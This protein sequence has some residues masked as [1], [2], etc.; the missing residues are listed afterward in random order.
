VP[1]ESDD[2]REDPDHAALERRLLET[3]RAFRRTGVELR[4]L[5]LKASHP[6]KPTAADA[7]LHAHE[8]VRLLHEA[9]EHYTRYVWG[10]TPSSERPD[11][12]AS[13]EEVRAGH[14]AR[15]VA[16]RADLRKDFEERLR[17]EDGQNVTIILKD[18]DR[19][20][21]HRAE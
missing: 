3:M 14:L 7:Q 6:P 20:R 16:A 18:A 5:Y 2:I 9:I 21:H 8:A 4:R 17:T 12:L 13:I 10:L 1:V 15:L 11:H 19:T